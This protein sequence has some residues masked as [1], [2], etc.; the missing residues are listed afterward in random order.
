MKRRV[1][2][3]NLLASG[4]TVGAGSALVSGRDEEDSAAAQVGLR[5]PG[6]LPEDEF[7]S[8]C[9]RCFRCGDACP[10]RAIVALNEVSGADFSRAP[11]SSERGTPVIFPR[12]QA[13]M[14]CMGV[15]TDELCCTAACPTGA[16]GVVSKDPDAIQAAV[17]MGKASVD[18]NICY[19]F[20]GA[21]CGVCV[22][23]CPFEGKALKA[24]Y[25]E[26]PVLDPDF[27]V[28][29]GLCERACIRYPQA[30]SIRGPDRGRHA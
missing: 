9:I 4:L 13:C 2:L 5:P 28:G 16:L 8:R 20:N 27:C 22:R 24:G 10:N 6:A 1:F 29:C 26:R 14:L 30:I 3:R 21:S 17:D 23:A 25:F 11:R 7:L 19:S 12:R 18:T 15:D